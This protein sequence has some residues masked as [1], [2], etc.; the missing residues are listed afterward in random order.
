[1]TKET[2]TMANCF[3]NLIL[4]HG[5]TK[6]AL[7]LLCADSSNGTLADQNV[8]Q[9]KELLSAALANR[10]QVPNCDLVDLPA[11]IQLCNLPKSPF[12]V[13]SIMSKSNKLE[14]NQSLERNDSLVMSDRPQLNSEYNEVAP[15]RPSHFMQSEEV[16]LLVASVQR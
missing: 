3:L 15:Q 1:M 16:N 11:F 9:I 5:T 8:C 7:M 6:S 13:A 4:L 14:S 12:D 2:L 10:T